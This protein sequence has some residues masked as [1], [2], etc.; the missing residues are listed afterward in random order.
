MLEKD[1]KISIKRANELKKQAVLD[2]KGKSKVE[3]GMSQTSI[4][5]KNKNKLRILEILHGTEEEWND[6]KWQ[7]KNRITNLET[8]LKIHNFS[9]KESEDIMK[10]SKI[11]RFAITPY[12]LSLIN[13][14]N[15][16]C[17]I[18]KQCFPN[19]LELDDF[20][21]LDPMSE[22]ITNPSGTITRRYPNKLIIN[23]TNS[24]PSYCR[25]CQRRRLIGEKDIETSKELIDESIKYIRE[26][27]EI[28]EVLITG[29]DALTVTNEKLED[30]LKKLYSI[31]HVEILRLG[32]RVLAT[33]PQRIND[34]L[35]IMLRK[36]KVFV[37]TQFNHALELTP[38]AIKAVDTL[39][40]HGVQ[41]RNQMVL[42]KGIN[43]DKYIMQKTNEELVKARVIPYYL[44]HPKQV[45]GTGHFQVSIEKGLEIMKHLEGH[46]SGMCKP[47]YI[48][49]AKG[50]L[51]KVPLF[52]IQNLEQTE[53]GYV[54]TTWENK[55][56]II[57]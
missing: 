55:K 38:E 19:V 21:E 47:T 57:E 46:T 32:T 1:R 33:M 44:F 26:N 29:G 31:K 20:G 53:K 16:N 49:N 28:R 13:F 51:G 45:K 37:A 10:V 43:D 5:N 18:K 52:P 2:I 17:P 50:G 35:A 3:F 12:Y 54:I 4:D 9:Q 36:Y 6:P 7:M 41:V 27:E 22:K 39:V 56:I 34:E 8:L 14:D 23:I 15:P 11:Y 24:C 25:H 48:L 40:D 42:L 30:I